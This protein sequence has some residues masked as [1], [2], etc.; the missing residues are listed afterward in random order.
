MWSW[1]QQEW[2]FVSSALTSHGHVVSRLRKP[3]LG[4]LVTRVGNR[5]RCF[6]QPCTLREEGITHNLGLLHH[7]GVL[8][9]Y[10]YASDV[11]WLL[12]FLVKGNEDEKAFTVCNLSVVRG[13]FG[14]EIY[15]DVH[16]VGFGGSEPIGN[17]ASASL[18]AFVRFRTRL[19]HLRLLPPVRCFRRNTCYDFH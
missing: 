11:R 8:T 17:G 9:V 16:D 12:R 5:R 15:F 6:A 2:W 14:V 7:L 18:F 13:V 3:R 19:R 1:A 4:N 10:G